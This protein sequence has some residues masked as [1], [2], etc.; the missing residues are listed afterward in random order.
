MSTLTNPISAPRAAAAAE[1]MPQV[2][3]GYG[4][5]RLPMTSAEMFKG[6]QD[7][8]Q[9]QPATAPQPT[10]ATQPQPAAP[11][12]APPAATQ[13]QPQP[14]T[15]PEG[16]VE[17]P[18]WRKFVNARISKLKKGATPE[19]LAAIE[20]EASQQLDKFADANKVNTADAA[21][22]NASQKAA[23]GALAKANSMR[24]R[25]VPSAPLLTPRSS[26]P[27]SVAGPM[28]PSNAAAAGMGAAMNDANN[29][30][31]SRGGGVVSTERGGYIQEGAGGTKSVSSPYGATGSGAGAGGYS[32]DTGKM[33]PGDANL[34]GQIAAIKSRQAGG[35][36]SPTAPTVPTTSAP[37]AVA[38]APAPTP[39][40]SPSPT[41]QVAQAPRMPSAN[42]TMAGTT[43]AGVMSNTPPGNAPAPAVAAAPPIAPPPPNRAEEVLGKPVI[44][45]LN[46]GS[47]FIAGSGP[48]MARGTPSTPT[49]AMPKPVINNLNTGSNFIA[50]SGPPMARG[51]QSAP[52]V[53]ATPTPTPAPTPNVGSPR[54]RAPSPTFTPEQQAGN[55]KIA[56]VINPKPDASVI[57]VRPN[58]VPLV[59]GSA[60]IA[61]RAKGGPVTAGR[62]YLVGEKGPEMVVARAKGGPVTAGQ[63]YLVGEKGPEVIVPQASGTVIPNHKLSAR[64]PKPPLGLVLR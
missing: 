52:A 56:N 44:N 10:T 15:P 60:P 51:P 57:R 46:T 54:Y 19:E 63:P 41:P 32:I 50:G 40:V 61:A 45:N 31:T 7:S 13:A 18:T 27:P 6:I 22:M 59:G 11:T 3:P 33:G 42:P 26:A 29:G 35:V 36:F 49:V 43:A 14:D 47:N 48:P 2:Q 38:A 17:N 20:E 16:A 1:P 8:I 37:R 23:E 58:P 24:G 21:T 64:M 62:P 5:R 39:P 25:T 30:I 53:A 4:V 12:S 34:R 28:F 9:P 55:A